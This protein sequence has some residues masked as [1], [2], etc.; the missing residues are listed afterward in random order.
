MVKG[1]KGK[2]EISTC[3]EKGIYSIVCR[4]FFHWILSFYC[5]HCITNVL[6][7]MIMLMMTDFAFRISSF[8]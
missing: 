1:G 6:M 2:K 5:K 4:S 3:T 7:M 8:H